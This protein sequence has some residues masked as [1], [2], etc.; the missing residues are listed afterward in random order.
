MIVCA[1]F[2]AGKR[3]P[4]EGN[5]REEEGKEDTNLDEWMD[6]WDIWRR[7]EGIE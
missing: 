5:L 3:E 2:L 4:E 1:G 7:T 6:K